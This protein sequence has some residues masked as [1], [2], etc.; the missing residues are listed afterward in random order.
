MSYYH[1]AKKGKLRIV[2]IHPTPEGKQAI[3]FEDDSCLEIER[4]KQQGDDY[5][6]KKVNNRAEAKEPKQASVIWQEVLK[7]INDQV[8]HSYY[9]AWLEKTSGLS[10]EGDLFTVGV[11]NQDVANH[12][13]ENRRSL[14]ENTLIGIIGVKVEVKFV[15]I[16]DNGKQPPKEESIEAPASEPE[17]ESSK[18]TEAHL[19]VAHK[20]NEAIMQR[21]FSKRQRKVLDLILRLSWGCN[22]SVAVIPYQR[23]FEIVGIS[24]SKVKAE[25]DWLI[26]S[27]IITRDNDQYQ[28][29]KNFEEWQVSRVKP[30]QPD[31]LAKLVSLNIKDAY[32]NSK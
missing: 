25:L 32:Q 17:A 1:D 23:D 10:Y 12:L 29:N 27:R 15:D 8:T 18:T 31:K 7:K 14:I 13:N 20:I 9:S 5:Y 30:F 6:P 24:E 28:F 26:S 4:C 21:D 16:S 19:R 11:P 3:W 22:K 2:K